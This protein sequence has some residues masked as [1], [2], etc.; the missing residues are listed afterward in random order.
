MVFFMLL[1]ITTVADAQFREPDEHQTVLYG[2]FCPGSQRGGPYGA[3][4]PV[5]IGEQARVI[6]ERCFATKDQP[7]HIGKI[8]ENQWYFDVEI[9]DRGSK[10]VDR[11]ILDK[12]NGRVRSVYGP[13]QARK[14]LR[15]SVDAR[16]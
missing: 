5:H 9:L 6:V 2:Q 1:A 16:E 4:R 12:R 7:A 13:E 11:V 14:D 15:G 10:V 3:R 8:Q